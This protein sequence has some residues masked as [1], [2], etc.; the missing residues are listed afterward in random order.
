MKTALTPTL[1]LSIL[2]LFALDSAKANSVPP[3][4]NTSIKLSSS[5]Q[6]NTMIELY[7]SE[8]CSS[9]PP[10]EARLN[11][12]IKDKN[13]WSSIIPIAFHVDYWDY[14]GWRDRF[15]SPEHGKRQSRYAKLNRERTVYTPAFVVNGKNWRPGIIFNKTPDA[16]TRRV[17]KLS[18][19]I[20]N[21]SIQAHFSA[22]EKMETTE[23]T[24]TTAKANQPLILNIAVLGMKLNSDIKRGENAGRKAE[25][26]FVVLAQHQK[27]SNTMNW[28][29]TLPALKNHK[30]TQYALVAWVSRAA[31]PAPI[32]AVG[33]Y[34]PNQFV[35]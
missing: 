13:L 21:K 4:N 28:Q 20:Q 14:I 8:G 22:V 29:V 16:K 34:I 19:T 5:E 1:L 35:E 27:S 18:L 33:G 32:Q 11:R 24:E 10:A 30:A 25:H 31:H 2:L 23:K 3:G 17:G 15:A 9:C 6:Q 12:Y 26:H 7:T